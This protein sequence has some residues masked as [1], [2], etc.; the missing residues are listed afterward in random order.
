MPSPPAPLLT[1][2]RISRSPCRK[3]VPTARAPPCT[4]S[5]P[6]ATVTLCWRCNRWMNCG[7]PRR[8]APRA[9][10]LAAVHDRARRHRRLLARQ[11]Q[12]RAARL[13]GRTGPAASPAAISTRASISAM[14]PMS[15]PC[16]RRLSTSCSRASTTP[17]KA[18]AVSSPTPP[19][20]CARRSPSSAAKPTWPFLMNA[21]PPNT[22][23]PWPSFWT[24][25]AASPAW[26]TTC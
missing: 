6:A 12:P 3:P 17:S 20:S 14:P 19:T 21:P 4:A 5:P 24:N 11:A 8:R 15:S 10:H 7:R 2:H 18:C 13:D 25:R 16:S 1:R 26:W 22:A 9:L 23:S